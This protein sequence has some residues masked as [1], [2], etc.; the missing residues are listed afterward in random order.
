MADA[1]WYYTWNQ[2]IEVNNSGTQT[3]DF[4]SLMFNLGFRA[5]LFNF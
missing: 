1:R 4:S 2:K 5:Y 3:G